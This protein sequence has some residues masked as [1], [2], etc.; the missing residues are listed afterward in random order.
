MAC[1]ACTGGTSGNAPDWPSII[2]GKRRK[3]KGS[4]GLAKFLLQSAKDIFWRV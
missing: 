3:S 1:C 2:V 4:E